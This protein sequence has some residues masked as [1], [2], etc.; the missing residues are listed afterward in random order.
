MNL[1]LCRNMK[2]QVEKV[3]SIGETLVLL[4]NR[5]RKM[6]WPRNQEVMTENSFI[7]MVSNSGLIASLVLS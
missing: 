5:N 4:E 3:S 7:V 2:K 6:F 1:R